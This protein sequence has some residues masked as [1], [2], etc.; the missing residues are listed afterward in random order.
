MS[1]GYHEDNTFFYLYF[2]FKQYKVRRSLNQQDFEFLQ[3]LEKRF[4]YLYFV[5][6]QYKV[7][8]SLNQQDFEFLQ[9]LE[10]RFFYYTSCSNNIK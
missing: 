6:K 1:K 9:I 5:F 2:V 4:F 7:R 10:K 8:R 3:I